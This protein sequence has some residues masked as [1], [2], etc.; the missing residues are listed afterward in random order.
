MV[1][2]YCEKVGIP[3]LPES[4]TWEP[5]FK[6]EWKYWESWHLD[7]GESTG[8]KK[9]MEESAVHGRRRA[10]SSRRCTSSACRYYEKMYEVRLRP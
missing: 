1:K 8:F 2:Q 5:E 9:D 4:L 3:F 6:P 10:A 7:A